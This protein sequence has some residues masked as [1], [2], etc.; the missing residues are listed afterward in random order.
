MAVKMASDEIVDF[1]L[2]NG[3]QVLEFMHGGKFHDVETVG[4]DAILTDP[5][6]IKSRTNP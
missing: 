3:M 1:L 4:Q 5:Y 2:G 6:Q